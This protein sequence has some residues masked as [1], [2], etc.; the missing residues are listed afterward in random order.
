[1]TNWFFFIS[2][3]KIRLCL[4]KINA[5]SDT[6]TGRCL[7][8]A[9][10]E[11]QNNGIPIFSSQ[12]SLSMNMRSEDIAVFM[13]NQLRVDLDTF[14]RSYCITCFKPKKRQDGI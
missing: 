7:M 12:K 8:F 1:M 11:R 9:E 3:H 4:K 13:N 14:A 2:G 5:G 6:D 10:S